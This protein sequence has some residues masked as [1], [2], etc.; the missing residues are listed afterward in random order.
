V[1]VGPAEMLTGTARMA[2]EAEDKENKLIRDQEIGRKKR[3]IERK[4]KAL[5]VRIAELRAEFE[6]E[7]ENLKNFIKDAELKEKVLQ[8]D[9]KRI[10]KARGKD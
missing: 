4:Q 7:E 3:E 5:D 10:G 6:A 1:Y 2:R 9:R 8:E